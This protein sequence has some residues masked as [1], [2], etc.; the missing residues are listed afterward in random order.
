MSRLVILLL[1]GRSKISEVINIDECCTDRDLLILL[2]S[3]NS[4]H[5]PSVLL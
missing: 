2:R 1:Q 3:L 5:G 4:S